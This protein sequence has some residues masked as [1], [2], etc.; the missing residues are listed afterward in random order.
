M[1]KG[2]VEEMEDWDFRVLVNGVEEGENVGFVKVA[3]IVV[4]WSFGERMRMV[5]LEIGRAHV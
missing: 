2:R 3:A 4:V 1:E 5:V